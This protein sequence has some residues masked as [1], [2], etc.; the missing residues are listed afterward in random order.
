MPRGRGRRGT[1]CGRGG[2]TSRGSN[3]TS[4]GV[5]SN[6]TDQTPSEVQNTQAIQA[7]DRPRLTIAGNRDS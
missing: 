4:G 2:G 3:T 5:D 6:S 1:Q 7:N